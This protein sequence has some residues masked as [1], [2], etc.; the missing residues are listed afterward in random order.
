MKLSRFERMINGRYFGVVCNFL[1][2]FVAVSCQCERFVLIVVGNSIV[3]IDHLQ[4]RL[5]LSLATSQLAELDF[6]AALQPLANA[7]SVPRI[8]QRFTSHY[9]LDR[10]TT[11][12]R[13]PSSIDN[14][15]RLRIQ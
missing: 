13:N 2:P 11:S 10:I 4:R 3:V 8:S 12:H 7:Y 14:D 9:D 1:A 15:T 5:M 6:A